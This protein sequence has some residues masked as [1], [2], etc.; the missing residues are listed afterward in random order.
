MRRKRPPALAFMLRMSTLRRLARVLSLAALD[1]AG[2]WLAIFVAL[3]V[4]SVVLEH[5][6]PQ[7][8]IDQTQE[9][10]AFAYLLTVLLFA[11]SGLYADRGSR[12]GLRSIVSSLFQVTV[13]ALI[14]A[15]VNGEELLLVLHLLRVADLRHRDRVAAALVLRAVHRGDPPRGRLPAP[16]G[17]RRH[18]ART[19]TRSPTRWATARTRR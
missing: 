2:I 8:Q 4:K 11:R 18:R 7:A 17:A 13:V 5:W 14:F 3:S 6:D 1:F 9:I 19:S 10:V 16:R 15:L 12:P